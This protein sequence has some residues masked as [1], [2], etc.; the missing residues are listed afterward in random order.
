MSKFTVDPLKE[1]SIMYLYAIRDEIDFDPPYQRQGDIWPP[2]KKSLLIDSLLNGFD[3]PKIYFH[4]TLKKSDSKRFAVID[5]KQRLQAIFAFLDGEFPVPVEYV[6]MA[7][8]FGGFKGKYY[9]EF[10]STNLKLKARFESLP[11][12]VQVV[13]T[14]D[15]ELIEEMFSRLNEASTLNAAEKRNAFGGPIPPLIKKLTEHAFFKK[16]PF[17]NHRYRH[18]EVAAKLLLLAEKG[19]ITDTKR[20]HLDRF[21]KSYKG[22]N[23]DSVQGLADKVSAYLDHMTEVFVVSD[24][25]LKLVTMVPVYFTLFMI[26]SSR[27]SASKISRSALLSFDEAKRKNRELAQADEENDTINY[28]WLEFDR[29]TQS[30]NDSSSIEFK[31]NVLLEY[32]G[33]NL[34][35]YKTL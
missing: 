22:Q 21:V 20:T 32:L 11:L 15:V 30:P 3:L 5:G 18:Y 31:T 25:L 26:L 34:I 24:K 2:S 12:P 27:G 33:E 23:S 7:G 6:D 35:S 4:E 13:R 19:K 14:N 10:S 16:L 29:L 28:E 9:K 1:N 17:D 8:L